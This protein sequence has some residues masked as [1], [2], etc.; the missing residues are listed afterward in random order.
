MKLALPKQ[1]YWRFN[2]WLLTD[3]EFIK[4]MATRFEEFLETN[5]TGD[6]SD[7]TLWEALRVVMQGHTI[8]FEASKK[9]EQHRRLVEIENT[10]PH[11]EQ[12]YRSSLLQEES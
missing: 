4:Y 1:R 9:R 11:L 10:L 8:S 6:V 12:N 2:P 7:F 5:D 3:Q